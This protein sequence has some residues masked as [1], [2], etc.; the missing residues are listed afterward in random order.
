[1]RDSIVF[2]KSFYEAIQNIPK[3]EQLKLYNAIF[4]YSFTEKE[5]IIDEGIAKAMFILIKP[6]IDS[7]NAR[8]KASVENGKKGGRP[9]KETQEKPKQNLEKTQE[10]PK[11]N[12]NDNV[13]DNVNDNIKENN[14]KK[15]PTLEEIQD[16]IQ[17]KQLKV[18]GKQFYDYFTEGN[19]VDAKGN[20]VKN[21]KQKLLTW[22][23]YNITKKEEPKKYQNYEQ[24][25][26]GDLS[27]LYANREV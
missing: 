27:K 18:D 13:N 16:Y 12:L 14:K 24:R 26:Y 4:E 21:W 22:N 15:N 2:Y 17:E 19:W 25:R 20:K 1:M 6:N 5:P 9:R 8:Y 23:K 7:A 11:Q 10:K 3:E